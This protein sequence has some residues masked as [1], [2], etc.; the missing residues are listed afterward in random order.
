MGETL[1]HW[2]MIFA[3]HHSRLGLKLLS[4][5]KKGMTIEMLPHQRHKEAALAQLTTV[6]ADRTNSLVKI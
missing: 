2:M 1:G 6:C 3:S 5:S 4:L